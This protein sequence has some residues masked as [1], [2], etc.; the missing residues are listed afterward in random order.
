MLRWLPPRAPA[1]RRRGRLSRRAAL[2]AGSL[3]L[4][5][6]LAAA[7]PA[8]AEDGERGRRDLRYQIEVAGVQV[9]R[10]DVA[11]DAGPETAEARVRWRIDG[12]LGL[13]DR[14]EGSLEAEGRV[15]DGGR[16]V[17]AVFRSL[18]EKPDRKREVS[19]RYGRGGD[20]R[21]LELRR[22]GRSRDSEV[23]EDLRED[24][25]DTVTAFW[26]LR[27]WLAGDDR[28]GGDEERVA[29]FDGRRRYDLLARRLGRTTAELDG[30]EVRAERVEL[31]L[32]PHAGF[33]DDEKL[34]GNRIDPDAP[35]AELLVTDG[36]GDAVPL[37][38]A[39]LG[40]MKWRI[41]LDGEGRE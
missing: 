2:A 36:E 26:R 5:L 40:R 28:R 12:L 3:L 14:E 38:L 17:P 33:D 31:T 37:S 20:I 8:L 4:P 41:V 32:V 6:L 30:R 23:P 24:T 19:I 18:F 25:V 7:P 21:N 29:V 15:D 11:A 9:G 16:V 39:G 10:V 22:D 27:E 13:L 1:A 34:F 35:W